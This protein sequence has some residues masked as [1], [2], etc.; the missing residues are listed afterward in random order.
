VPRAVGAPHCLFGASVDLYCGALFA[1]V[2]TKPCSASRCVG[3]QSVRERKGLA[4]RPSEQPIQ[5]RKR[6]SAKGTAPLRNAPSSPRPQ[7]RLVLAS[8]RFGLCF[9]TVR[10][11]PRLSSAMLS[12]AMCHGSPPAGL[13]LAAAQIGKDIHRAAEK[14][15]KLTKLAKSKSLFDDPAAEISQ[16]SYVITQDIN[17]LNEGLGVQGSGF[18]IYHSCPP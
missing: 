1:S 10:I 15:A 14:L 18:R 3:A 7:R 13:C 2:L 4:N 12:H 6:F 5:A 8:Y 17:R 16:L 11:L 9:A